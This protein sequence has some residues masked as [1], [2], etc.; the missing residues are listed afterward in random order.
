MISCDVSSVAVSVLMLLLPVG[1]AGEREPASFMALDA[2]DSMSGS[3][4]RQPERRDAGGLLH[5]R[6]VLDV[7][8]TVS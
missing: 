8:K 4:R 3:Q 1:S 7:L 5:G 6:E 2:R